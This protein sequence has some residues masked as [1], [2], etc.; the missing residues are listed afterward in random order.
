MA[1]T[2]RR[3]VTGKVAARTADTGHPGDVV[4]VLDE[5]RVVQVVLLTEL[6]DDSRVRGL[7]AEEGENGVAGH[8]EHQEIDEQGGSEED[9]DHLQKT[10]QN[11]TEHP[12]VPSLRGKESEPN[13]ACEAVTKIATASQ[14]KCRQTYSP[15][16]VIS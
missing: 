5:E 11:V 13:T 14:V 2:A 3:P 1:M 8:G 4:P 15:A 16:F 9:R 12:L 10:S 6:L 7:V